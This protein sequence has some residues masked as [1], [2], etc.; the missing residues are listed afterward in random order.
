VNGETPCW[1][2]RARIEG[3]RMPG[4]NTCPSMRILATSV[5]YLAKRDPAMEAIARDLAERRPPR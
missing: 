3:S 4:R 1:R 2:A 5:A